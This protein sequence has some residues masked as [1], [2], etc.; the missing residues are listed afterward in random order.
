MIK[1]DRMKMSIFLIT[2]FTEQ[3]LRKLV[4]SVCNETNLG[5]D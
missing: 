5:N 1:K 3:T 2:G 4:G